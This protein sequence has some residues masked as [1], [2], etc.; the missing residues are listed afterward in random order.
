MNTKTPVL[1]L[2]APMEKWPASWQA[3][4]LDLAK[5]KELVA[6]FERFL[7]HLSEQGLAPSTMRRHLDNL[8]SLGGEIIT[9]IN[10]YP[11]ERKKAALELLDA[12]IDEEGGPLSRHLTE[13]ETKSFD[14]T[15]RKLHAFLKALSRRPGV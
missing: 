8:W 14:A 11:E 12:S 9:K 3:D 15:C 1:P 5:G 4:R 13:N 6:V 7:R 10:H 2:I